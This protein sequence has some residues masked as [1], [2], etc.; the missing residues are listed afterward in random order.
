MPSDTRTEQTDDNHLILDEVTCDD[1]NLFG[2][3]ESSESDDLSLYSFCNRCR[4]QGGERVLKRRMRTPWSTAQAIENT[5]QAL[6]FVNGN[7]PA[8]TELPPTYVVGNV[9]DYTRDS[10]PI[11]Q[12]R[13][14]IE[15]ASDAFALLSL[16]HI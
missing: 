14:V 4:T 10:A 9:D 12:D 3:S 15:F 1:L 8:F 5:Q 7:D 2:S 6:M 11:I 16:I 13:G